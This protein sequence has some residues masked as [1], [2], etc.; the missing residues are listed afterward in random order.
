M[1]YESALWT[2][3]GVEREANQD[4]MCLHHAQTSQG[5]LLMGVVCDGM[6]GYEKGELASA[7]VVRAFSY[8]FETELPRMLELPNCLDEI[9]YRWERIVQEQN[10]NIAEYGRRHRI[11]LGTTMTAMLFF[12]DGRYVMGHIGDTRAYRITN[13]SAEL[14]TQDHTLVD[15][16][17]REG[18]ITEAQANDHPDRNVLTRCI[19]VSRTVKPEISCGSAM[20][21]ECYLLCSDGFR[22]E[23][24]SEELQRMFA[25]DAVRDEGDLTRNLEHMTHVNI[26]RGETDNI[27]ALVIKVS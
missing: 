5:E 19:G 24:S 18:R 7:E 26:D 4:S 2:D 13:W 12:S 15:Q 11:Q 25:P 27:S 8:W 9:Q 6:G 10:Q 1:K 23:V 3:I 14:L 16:M 22:H 17:V 21:D 20:E